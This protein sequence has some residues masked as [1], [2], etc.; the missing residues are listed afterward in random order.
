MSRLIMRIQRHVETVRDTGQRHGRLLQTRDTCVVYRV[1]TRAMRMY[2]CDPCAPH[3]P[4]Q[5]PA[6]MQRLGNRPSGMK[7]N[8]EGERKTKNQ[9]TP[10]T[11][12]LPAKNLSSTGLFP[13]GYHAGP[14]LARL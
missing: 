8:E 12:I 14:R 3:P 13:A 4:K 10:S 5:L 6:V 9:F 7:G 1:G 11:F 2:G